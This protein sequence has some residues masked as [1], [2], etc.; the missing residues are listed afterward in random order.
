M[1]R[2]ELGAIWEG[3]FDLDI[4]N[5]FGNAVHHISLTKNA[6]ALAHEL[7]HCF[8]VSC[9]FHHGRTDVGNR[10]RVVQLQTASFSALSQ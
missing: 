4:W 8:T 6:A 9:T 7:R 10:F 2:D 3:G 5:H 1:H